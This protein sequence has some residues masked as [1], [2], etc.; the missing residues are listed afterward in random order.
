MAVYTLYSFSLSVICSREAVRF[1]VT[2]S[3]TCILL[4]SFTELNK[5]IFLSNVLP[6]PQ[7]NAFDWSGIWRGDV[8]IFEATWQTLTLLTYRK[9]PKISPSVY[10]PLR[11]EAP[12]IWNAKIPHIIS[13][14]KISPRGLVFGSYP[15][16]YKVNQRKLQ[17]ITI[18][19]KP[20]L[21]IKEWFRA[22]K[23]CGQQVLKFIVFYAVRS[24]LAPWISPSVRW[25]SICKEVRSRHPEPMTQMREILKPL[26][27]RKLMKNDMSFHSYRELWAWTT[28]PFLQSFRSN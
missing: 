24:S 23:Q 13:P 18:I 27:Q 20:F 15:Q 21:V 5:L 22:L 1:P 3:A 8:E 19:R 26:M 25:Q 14:P 7:T 6:L 11:I 9:I 12:Q 17:I 28:L 2:L 16:L 10:K 4:L